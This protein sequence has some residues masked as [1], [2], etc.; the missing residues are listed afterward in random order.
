MN[1]DREHSLFFIPLITAETEYEVE[2]RKMLPGA[3]Q[4]KKKFPVLL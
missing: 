1:P 4:V 3:E 2:K